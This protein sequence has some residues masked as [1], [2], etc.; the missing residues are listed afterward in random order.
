MYNWGVRLTKNK[1]KFFQIGFPGHS[2]PRSV[3]AKPGQFMGPEY[4]KAMFRQVKERNIRVDEDT[5]ITDLLVT[6]NSVAGAVGLD[7]RRGEVKAYQAKT[8]ILATGGFMGCYSFTTANKTA[9]GDGHGLA[10]RAGVKLMD[11][12][13]I[14]FLPAATLAPKTVYGDP[15]PYLLWVSLHPI[16]YNI[17]GEPFLERYYPDVKNWATREA[18][19]RAI[20]KEVK[21]GRGSPNGGAYMSFRHLPRNLLDDFLEKASGVDYMVKLKNAG[22]DLRYDAIEVFP[23]A[24]YVAGGCWVNE[25]CETSHDNLYAV[26]EVSSGGKDGADRLGGNSIPFCMAM[27]FTAGH[28]A[29]AKAK[30]DSYLSLDQSLVKKLSNRIQAPMERRD[31]IRPV[32]I[33]KAVRRIMSDNAFVERDGTALEQAIDQLAE[34]REKDLPQMATVAKNKTFNTE[35]VDALETVNMV[36][37]AEMVCR[38]ALMRTESRGLHQRTDFPKTDPGWL[39]RILIQKDADGMKL[40]TESVEFPLVQPE[41]EDG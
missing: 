30:N 20:F 14:Q 6:D 8:T 32:E 24:H 39:K 41:N 23:S 38:S 3:V 28:E 40:E 27:G 13:F 9:T 7:I 25:Q 22:M 21:A 16:F 34:I 2:H 33:K 17:L 31:G 5:F 36:Q 19:A 15:Y 12:E 18:A 29:A 4:R 11:M 26:G 37:I 10:F 35:W 1:G